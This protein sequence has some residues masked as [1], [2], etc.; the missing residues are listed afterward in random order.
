MVQ[1]HDHPPDCFGCKTRFSS[2]WACLTEAELCAMS[3]EKRTL[4][5]SPGD[6]I[7]DQGDAS[8][9]VYCIQSGLVGLRRLDRDGNSTLMRL[10][11]PGET[12][13]YRSFL[14]NLPHSNCAEILM[15]S[16][17]CFVNSQ[18]VRRMLEENTALDRSFLDHCLRDLSETEDRY[19]ESVT[20]KAK[21]R[22]LHLL[23]L[24]YHRFGFVDECG[25]RLVELPVS[26]QDLA[27][28]V[29]TTPETL[30]RLIQRI[31]CEG[32]AHF[33]GRHVQIPN[34]EKISRSLPYS[35]GKA[36]SDR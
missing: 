20:W 6:T 14:N 13:G 22:L 34:I 10:V 35:P 21:A 17:V 3:R 7:Y 27:D 19:M 24:L 16:V 1:R 25:A 28:L 4:V 8:E 30:S 26:R 32:L 33:D 23:L 18:A 12:V 15:P 11:H 9:G 5:F 29:G 2:E 36:L 31:Q